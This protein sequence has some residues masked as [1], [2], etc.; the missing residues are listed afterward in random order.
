[1]TENAIADR[2]ATKP[3]TKVWL[4]DAVHLELDGPIAALLGPRY[5]LHGIFENTG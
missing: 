3:N 2:L 4:L 5:R 1:M